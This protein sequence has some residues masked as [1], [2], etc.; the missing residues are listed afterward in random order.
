MQELEHTV[1]RGYV[2]ASSN[3]PRLLDDALWRRFDQTLFFS[4]PSKEQL[5]HFVN[6][7]SRYFGLRKTPSLKA[8][9]IARVKTFADARQFIE[10]ERRRQ[11]LSSP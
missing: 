1:P 6:D 7:L 10:N 9:R 8:L 5:R 3:I 2:V 4:A 11:L